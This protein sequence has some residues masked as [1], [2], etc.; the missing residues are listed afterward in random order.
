MIKKNLSRRCEQYT[1]DKLK[2]R[3]KCCIVVIHMSAL[4]ET[5]QQNTLNVLKSSKDSCKDIFVINIYHQ[6]S[7][8]I[9]LMLSFTSG[10][11][12]C[13]S[14]ILILFMDKSTYPHGVLCQNCVQQYRIFCK[15]LG[16]IG[17]INDSQY[18]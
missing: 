16:V 10:E 14:Y 8:G 9:I 13:Q 7:D 6:L 18:Y 5:M 15:W 4:I 3:L 1:W 11:F 2:L 17:F 12:D